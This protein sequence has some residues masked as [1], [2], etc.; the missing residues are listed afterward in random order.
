MAEEEG[1]IVDGLR[2]V[3]LFHGAQWGDKEK[4]E[5]TRITGVDEATTKV[6]CDHIRTLIGRVKA[7]EAL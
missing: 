1:E 6:L 5:W 4:R 3:L 7:G 2:A